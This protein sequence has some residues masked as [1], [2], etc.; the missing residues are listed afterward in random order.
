[1]SYQ[2][3]FLPNSTK[4][5]TLAKFC[6]NNFFT[7]NFAKNGKFLY[8]FFLISTEELKDKIVVLAAKFRYVIT[9]FGLG[10]AKLNSKMLELHNVHYDHVLQG[11]RTFLFL[12]KI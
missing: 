9:K 8:F 3:F 5:R 1:M 12:I 4:H 10:M 6:T 2:I 7:R 11:F